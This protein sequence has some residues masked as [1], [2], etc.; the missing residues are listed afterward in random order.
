MADSFGVFRLLCGRS[1]L[2]A[3]QRLDSSRNS[4]PTALRPVTPSKFRAAELHVEMKAWVLCHFFQFL[5]LTSCS[6]SLHMLCS[7]SFGVQPS[8]RAHQDFL[9]IPACQNH[10]HS[11]NRPNV[12]LPQLVARKVRPI[13]CCFKLKSSMKPDCKGWSPLFDGDKLQQMIDSHRK[14]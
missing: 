7:Q 6:T 4:T 5:S 3:W 13:I 2:W 11:S 14:P 9:F 1:Q 12:S 10:R 8:F